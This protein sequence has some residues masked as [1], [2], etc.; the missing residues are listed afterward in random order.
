MR[1]YDPTTG[2]YLQSDPLGLIDGASVYGYVRQSPMR[3]TD[4]TGEAIPAV[5]WGAV[6]LATYA[7][8]AYQ[9][10]CADDWEERVSIIFDNLNP[11]KR[12]CPFCKALGGG[13]GDPPRP[14]TPKER[15]DR[16]VQEAQDH[17]PNKA[18]KT[19]NHHVDPKYMGGDPKGETVPLDGAYHQRIT[20]EFRSKHS[21]GQPP[22]SP[23]DRKRIMEEVYDRFPLPPK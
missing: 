19:E 9:F 12:L 18:G 2:R 14:E 16:L 3:F 15:Y 23:T 8:I 21:Y 17:Y 20:N 13:K 6:R 11:S 22:L 10:Y 7:Y 4:P 5:V 1:D